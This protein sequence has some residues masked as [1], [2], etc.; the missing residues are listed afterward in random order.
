MMLSSFLTAHPTRGSRITMV[1]VACT[2]LR[3]HM[4]LSSQQ[5]PGQQANRSSSRCTT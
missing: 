1:Q 4:R 5:Y 2:T 3:D